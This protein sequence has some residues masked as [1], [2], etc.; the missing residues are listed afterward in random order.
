MT[1]NQYQEAAK[2]TAIYKKE[3][4]IGYTTLGLVCE[5]GQVAGKVK[6]VII[7]NNNR[8]K[9]EDLQ[10]IAKELGDVLWYVATLADDIGI[11]LEDIARINIQK[12][13]ARKEKVTISG[14]GD[15]R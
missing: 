15:N 5:A 3:H 13:T 1:L 12:L 11:D 6:K 9:L 7:D 8:F 2:Q 14:S 10:E 4:R